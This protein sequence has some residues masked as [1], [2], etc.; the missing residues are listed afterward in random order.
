MWHVSSRSGVAT[1]RTAIH[2]LLTS[3]LT[4][5]PLQGRGCQRQQ[6]VVSRCFCNKSAFILLPRIAALTLPA[7]LAPAA[8]I[9]RQSV[10]GARRYMPPALQQT[11]CTSLPL[12]IDGTDR[13]T[14]RRT[15]YRYADAHRRVLLEAAGAN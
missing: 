14:D 9:G 12:S 13:R 11:S 1:L 7:A 3:V 5:L 6:F 8:D 15:P 10:R 4:Y 2:L